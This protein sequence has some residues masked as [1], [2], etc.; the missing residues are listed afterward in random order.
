MYNKK[1]G[2]VYILLISKRLKNAVNIDYDPGLRNCSN[3][4]IFIVRRYRPDRS[5]RSAVRPFRLLCG[6]RA[7]TMRRPQ[8]LCRQAF[9]AFL[10]DRRTSVQTEQCLRVDPVRQKQAMPRA[11]LRQSFA[12]RRSGGSVIVESQGLQASRG[13]GAG[14]QDTH[15]PPRAFVCRSYRQRR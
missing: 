9:L 10:A 8:M 4:L 14:L 15:V 3:L 13:T 6:N 11:R 2:Y 1:V 7:C 12:S 5:E